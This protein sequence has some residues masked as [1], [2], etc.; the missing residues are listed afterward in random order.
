MAEQ[1]ISEIIN[2]ALEGLP[3]PCH[4]MS[5]VSSDVTYLTWYPMQQ[6]ATV[7]ASGVTRRAAQQAQVSIYSDFPIGEELNQVV[8][9]LK[10]AGLR[11]TQYGSQGYDAAS[12]RYN[13]PII[14][15]WAVMGEQII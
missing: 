3:W 14:V 10:A 15:Q 7:T 1:H 11:V 2:G 12:E 6:I 5:D 8:R 4:E 9:A 13:C